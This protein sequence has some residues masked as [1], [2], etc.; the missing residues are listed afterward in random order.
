M[1]LAKINNH[2]L[3]L[4]NPKLYKIQSLIHISMAFKLS[5]WDY[6]ICKN[7][8]FLFST[9]KVQ[10]NYKLSVMESSASKCRPIFNTELCKV[11]I[12]SSENKS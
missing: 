9:F 4:N 1:N 8:G 7:V 10:V 6:S 2:A 3:L 12:L 11:M 5:L